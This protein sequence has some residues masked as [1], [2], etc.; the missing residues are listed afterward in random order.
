[1]GW[2]SAG[3]S[4]SLFVPTSSVSLLPPRAVL[5]VP[6]RGQTPTTRPA[7]MLCP[8]GTQGYPGCCRICETRAALTSHLLLHPHCSQRPVQPFG[9]RSCSQPGKHPS[10]PASFLNLLPKHLLLTTREPRHSVPNQPL[11][12]FRDAVTIYENRVRILLSASS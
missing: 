11:Q 4:R 10:A 2:R 3:F 5:A 8:K 9:W 12:A 7:G 1:M 6:P